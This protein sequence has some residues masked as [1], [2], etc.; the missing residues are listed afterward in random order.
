LTSAPWSLFRLW[1]LKKEEIDAFCATLQNRGTF[2]AALTSEKRWMT[3]KKRSIPQLAIDT[4][5][6]HSAFFQSLYDV[7][8]KAQSERCAPYCAFGH[9]VPYDQLLRGIF[10]GLSQDGRRANFSKKSPRHFL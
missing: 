8:P 10:K 6:F 5:F 2:I 3:I 1:Q 4:E 7:K 9:W